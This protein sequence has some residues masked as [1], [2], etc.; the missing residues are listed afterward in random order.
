MH[1]IF[2][3]SCL[4]KLSHLPARLAQAGQFFGKPDGFI[5]KVDVYFYVIDG[6]LVDE[7]F[8][9]CS[10]HTETSSKLIT[11]L[12]PNHFFALSI[13]RSPGLL[14]YTAKFSLVRVQHT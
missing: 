2:G 5:F 3:Y 1:I 9:V 13:T 10:G 11:L 14:K 8:G 12:S 6:G 4:K 7:D